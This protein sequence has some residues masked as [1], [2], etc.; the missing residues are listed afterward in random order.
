MQARD[1]L[2]A[3]VSAVAATPE[4]R[5][6]LFWLLECAALYADPFGGTDAATNYLLGRQSIARMMLTKF[7]EINPRLY[8][9]ML[10]AV[11]DVRE[12]ERAA[13][14]KREENDDA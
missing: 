14:E 13:A 9:S 8:P 12:L 10:M 6:V 1:D 7:D 2:N 11:A 3:A 4:G 5:R